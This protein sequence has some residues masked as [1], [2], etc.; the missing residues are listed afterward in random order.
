MVYRLCH[1]GVL[2]LVLCP[3]NT[4]AT[5]AGVEEVRSIARLY[6][7]AFD[8]YPQGIYSVRASAARSSPPHSRM[9]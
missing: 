3:L 5:T 7:A 9:T 1:L 4:L 8:R 2:L 6:N